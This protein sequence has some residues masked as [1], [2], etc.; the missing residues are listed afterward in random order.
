MK[1]VKIPQSE[2]DKGLICVEYQII[3]ED[4]TVEL[5]IRQGKN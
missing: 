1:K 4:T 3:A 2:K 5:E